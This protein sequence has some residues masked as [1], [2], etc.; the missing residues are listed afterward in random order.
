MRNADYELVIIGGLLG[1]AAGLYAAR[2]GLKVFKLGKNETK[3][4]FN[5][6]SIVCVLRL[7]VV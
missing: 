1:F 2:S 3:H 6:Y 5:T 4:C 7:C